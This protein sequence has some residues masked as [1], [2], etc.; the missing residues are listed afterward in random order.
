MSLLGMPSAPESSSPITP[1]PQHCCSYSS[2]RLAG[3]GSLPRIRIRAWTSSSTTMRPTISVFVIIIK[4]NQ[5]GTQCR[6]LCWACHCIATSKLL[7][8]WFQNRVYQAPGCTWSRGRAAVNPSPSSSTG[9]GVYRGV[10]H[11]MRS[12]WSQPTTSRRRSSRKT[13]GIRYHGFSEPFLEISLFATLNDIKFQ[14]RWQ[15]IR[16]RICAPQ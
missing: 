7:D 10:E 11:G 4:L 5:I 16:H 6:N 12:T 14:A 9:R 13:R 2:R 8:F 1:W 15:G 3:I